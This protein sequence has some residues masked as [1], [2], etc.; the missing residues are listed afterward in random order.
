[1]SESGGVSLFDTEHIWLAEHSIRNTAYRHGRPK[2]QDGVESSKLRALRLRLSLSG[3]TAH[4]GIMNGASLARLG[5]PLASGSLSAHG[6]LSRPYAA[7]DIVA[8]SNLKT[9]IFNCLIVV[10]S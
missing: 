3:V 4:V 6:G 7:L 10:E 1:M 8:S 9:L 5:M 2:S